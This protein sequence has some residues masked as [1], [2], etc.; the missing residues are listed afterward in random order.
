MP[1]KEYDREAAIAYAHRWAYGRNPRYADFEQMGGDCTNFLSQCL[2]AGGAPMNYTPTLGWFYNSLN[3]RA[4]AWSGVA[5]FHRFLVSGRSPGPVATEVDI[6]QIRPGDFI[7]LSTQHDYFH[8]GC[9]V[10]AAGTIPAPDNIYV[11]AH[12]YDTDYRRLNTYNIRQMRC[13]HI[14]HLNT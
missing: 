12:T 6:S 13:L 9:I 2:Y 4:P 3:S 14:T 8:H 11:A 7:Q 10:V 1:T 5:E